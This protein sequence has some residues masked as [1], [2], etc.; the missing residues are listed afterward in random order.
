MSCLSVAVFAACAAAQDAKPEIEN[1]WVRVLRVFQVPGERAA[2]REQPPSVVVYLTNV[3]EKI[4]GADG[5]SREVM[6]KA[7]ETAYLEAGRRSQ[8]NLS[9]RP[10]EAVVIELKPARIHATP[11]SLDPVKLDPKYHI[12][13]FENDRVRVL[14]TILEPHIKSPMHEHPAYVVVY[15]TEL[16]TTMKLGDGSV[17]DNP[18]RPGEIAWRD[19]LKHETEN[20]GD[21]TAVEIQ[22]ELK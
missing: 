14:R 2:L 5:K 9:D 6:H 20:I 8:E 12:V 15:L 7:G 21:H 22:V 3:H 4:T 18:R 17:V 19:P 13:D 16:H 11:V 10:L 1:T